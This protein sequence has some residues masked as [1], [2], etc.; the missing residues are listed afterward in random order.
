MCNCWIKALLK[1][2][3]SDGV[4]TSSKFWKLTLSCGK[5]SVLV[6]REAASLPTPMLLFS[7]SP[8]VDTQPSLDLT[9]II[10]DYLTTLSASGTEEVSQGVD[11]MF[12]CLLQVRIDGFKHPCNSSISSALISILCLSLRI[13]PI[14]SRAFLVLTIHHTFLTGMTSQI[15]AAHTNHCLFDKHR[16]DL[17]SCNYF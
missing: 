12:G 7:R 3:Y 5:C 17:F 2:G 14:W 10:C 15:S 11:Y 4:I 13:N 8:H 6:L 16:F 9:I 1:L